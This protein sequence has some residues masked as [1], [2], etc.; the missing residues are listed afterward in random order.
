M[1]AV[2]GQGGALDEPLEHV[3]HALF[4]RLVGQQP[5]HAAHQLLADHLGQ[6]AEIP[7]VQPAGLE[8]VVAGEALVRALAGQADGDVLTGL[9][10]EQVE[11]HRAQVGHGLVQVV[12]GLLHVGGLERVQAQHPVVG[13]AVVG[14]DLGV[15]ELGE[16]LV[17]VADG[18]GLER[19][20]DVPP[21]ERHQAARVEPAG[22]EDTQ[23]H[24]RDQVAFDRRVQVRSQ[25]LHRLPEAGHGCGRAE[26]QIPVAGDLCPAVFPDEQVA[27]GQLADAGEHG[28][29]RRHELEA[30][31]VVQGLMVDPPLHARVLEDGL[32][33]RAEHQPAVLLRVVERLDADAVAGE[34]QPLARGVV[35]GEAEHAAQVVDHVDPVLLVAVQD[36]LG[37]GVAAEPV[38]PGFEQGPQF[39]EIVDLAVEHQADGVVLVEH[40]LAAVLAQVDDRQ[41]AEAE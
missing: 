4:L 40:R 8:P 26:A 23:R 30:E 13:L 10:A 18:E 3:D 19:A 31:V 12:E 41:P 28:L 29:R 21:H 22:E 15:V 33:L 36:H 27:G 25:L 5:G 14:D 2:L 32:D 6:Q 11:R 1:L 17:L 37:I 34:Q 20:A 35:Q 16:G 7:G 24:V 39:L 9:L 38:P